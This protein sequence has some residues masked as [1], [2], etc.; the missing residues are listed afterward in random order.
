MKNFIVAV[1]PVQE[2]QKT[3]IILNW[4]EK[5][6]I[7]FTFQYTALVPV[8]TSIAHPGGSQTVSMLFIF[9]KTS[10]FNFIQIFEHEYTE[11]FCVQVPGLVGK[12]ALSAG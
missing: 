1:L 12:L 3:L 2:S 11:D 8:P 9:G 4:M 10:D 6:D 5:N 7:D